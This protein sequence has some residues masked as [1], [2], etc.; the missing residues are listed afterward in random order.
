[1]RIKTVGMKVCRTPVSGA[2]FTL[3]TVAMLFL[4]ACTSSSK[5]RVVPAAAPDAAT[6]DAGMTADSFSGQWDMATRMG[7]R[8]VEAVLTLERDPA[9]ALQGIWAS[10]GQEMELFAIDVD[11]EAIAFDRQMGSGGQMLHFEGVLEGESLNGAW[12]GAFGELA[13]SGTRAGEIERVVDQHNRPM[14][15]EDG[16]TLL[17]GGG[18]EEAG[19]GETDWF[20]LTDSAIDPERFQYGVGRDSIPSIDDP[21]FVS[22]DDALLAQRGVSA[23]TP[24]LGVFVEGIARA[25]PVDVMDVHEIVNDEFGG[26]PYAVLW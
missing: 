7:N 8:D 22:P 20:D 9:G 5:P 13:S 25:Y 3:L 12:S 18:G 16:R 15:R 11:G 6:R 2:V 24:V 4:A 14:L 26:K 21:V 19:G 1:M 10:Q 17:W 23:E